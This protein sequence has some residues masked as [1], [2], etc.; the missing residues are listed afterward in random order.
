MTIVLGIKVHGIKVSNQITIQYDRNMVLELYPED[1]IYQ[2]I[3]NNSN[4]RQSRRSLMHSIYKVGNGMNTFLF[5]RLSLDKDLDLLE[6]ITKIHE[7]FD[8]FLRLNTYIF[9]FQLYFQKFFIFEEKEEHIN[10]VRIIDINIPI[11]RNRERIENRKLS[12]YRQEFDDL[13]NRCRK[14]L[15]LQDVAKILY[16][17]VIAKSVSSV[18]AKIIYYWNFYEHLINIFVSH[19]KKNLLVNIE[20]FEAL[21]S[22]V[23][24]FVSNRLSEF[25]LNPLNIA[26]IEEDIRKSLDRELNKGEHIGIVKRE[27]KNFKNEIV[28]HIKNKL[29][30]ED[31]LIE[32]YGI[33]NIAERI[34]KYLDNYP[35]QRDLYDAFVK[36]IGYNLS[37]TENDVVEY[38]K[39]SRN[40]LFHTSLRVDKLLDKL[41]KEFAE[42]SDI[43]FKD[44]KGVLRQF[45][46]YLRKITAKVLGREG[47]EFLLENVVKN[48]RIKKERNSRSDNDYSNWIKV[49][50]EKHFETLLNEQDISNNTFSYEHPEIE[51]YIR[52]SYANNADVLE[53]ISDSGS[54]FQHLLAETIEKDNLCDQILQ[55]TT[56]MGAC[57]NRESN[58]IFQAELEFIEKYAPKCTFQ[59]GFSF[60]QVYDFYID[61]GKISQ[62]LD[63]ILHFKAPV[64]L[65]GFSWKH[66]VY[67]S[68]IEFQF[69]TE[70]FY[71]YNKELIEHLNVKNNQK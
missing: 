55:K 57:Q 20:K 45:I 58:E 25:T 36:E 7:I 8:L 22:S 60:S 68:V 1:F 70:R 39:S 19:T 23:A 54:Y 27:W 38:M 26:R 40:F 31:L 63:A 12:K 30:K 56:L 28:G 71:E 2:H 6:F 59:E 69:E 34:T 49:F 47:E 44:L 41:K 64:N 61:L 15:L 67:I 11:D 52:E 9:N 32:E 46:T 43:T 18:E 65:E 53:E 42:L 14:S 62:K 17:F 13:V 24:E 51:R 5:T 35:S 29:V 66:T 16:E 4:S 3:N 10:L 21:K 33:E 50:T 37:Q 48:L